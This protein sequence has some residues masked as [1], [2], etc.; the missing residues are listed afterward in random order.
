[1][2]EPKPV[3]RVTIPRSRLGLPGRSYQL[4]G[5]PAKSGEPRIPPPLKAEGMYRI[6]LSLT[7]TVA[8]LHHLNFQTGLTGD[9]YVRFTSP[10]NECDPLDA[11]ELV[12]SYG[13]GTQTIQLKGGANAEGRLAEVTVEILAAGFHE[14]EDIAFG[15]I[16]PFRS[17]L[18]FD[19]DVPL[20]VSRMHVTQLSTQ[21]ASMTYVC[22]YSEVLLGADDFKNVPYV[23]SLLSLYREGINSYSPNYQFLCWYKIVEGINWKRAEEAS[24]SNVAPPLKFPERLANTKIEQRRH[25]EEAF[26]FI[27]QS[28]VADD[29]WDDLVPEE[30]LGWR[31]TISICFTSLGNG[32]AIQN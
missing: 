25:L 22:P 26:P 19:L 10:Q 30:V 9:S 15:A 31:V 2:S 18:A 17:S 29:T 14:A 12:V 24:K 16:S 32:L 28:G 5:Q 11:P 20:S 6:V 3:A 4:Y 13:R 1:M 27:K 21:R 23:Q 7:Q 8:D